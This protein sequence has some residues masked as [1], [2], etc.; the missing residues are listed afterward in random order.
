MDRR[1]HRETAGTA[2]A[3]PAARLRSPR[4]G[5]SE[6]ICLELFGGF[7]VSV[8]SRVVGEEEWRLRKAGSLVKLLALAQEHAMHRERILDLLWPELSPEAAATNLHRA[9]HFARR[10]L[11][12]APT[13]ATS[14]YL[15]FHGDL[16][17]LCPG[18]SLRVDVEAFESA[19]AAARRSREPAAYRAAI[20]LY[21]GDLLPEDRYEHWAEDRRR[22][23]RTVYLALLVELAALYEQREEP[24]PAIEALQKVV[25]AERTHEEAH[26]RLVRLYAAT[27][28]GREALLQYRRLR[29][30]LARAR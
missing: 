7:R 18:G 25:A 16:L 29:Q 1:R 24:A 5:E 12:P 19:A 15:A 13:T 8:G 28:R 20:E 14:R 23:L 2:Y 9:L 26:A 30:A 4:T 27:G 21:A 3:K 11:E 10:V 22:E 17:T 6:T